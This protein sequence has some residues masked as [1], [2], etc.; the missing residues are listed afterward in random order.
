MKS[1]VNDNTNN[2][3]EIEINLIGWNY[4]WKILTC[5]PIFKNRERLT[6]MYT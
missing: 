3:R 5:D 4:C 6:N 1:I 2:K